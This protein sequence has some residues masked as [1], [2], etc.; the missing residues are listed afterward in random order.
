M[1]SSLLESIEKNIEESHLQAKGISHYVKHGYLDLAKTAV[2]VII[3]I[4]EF[5]NTG[6][7]VI[8]KQGK[9]A[10]F[11]IVQIPLLP[12]KATCQ[13]REGE[14]GT[15]TQPL[16]ELHHK[17]AGTRNARKMRRKEMPPPQHWIPKLGCR[18]N[19]KAAF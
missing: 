7:V 18:W 19:S 8:V 6:N 13:P 15:Q 4:L 11:F 17:D 14:M 5:A 10:Y 12:W 9:N 3:V 1:E 2:S 16:K